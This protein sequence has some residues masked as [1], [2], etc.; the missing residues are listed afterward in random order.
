[1]LTETNVQSVRLWDPQ[2]RA[3]WVPS[4]KLGGTNVQGP[5]AMGF[6]IEGKYRVHATTKL[7]GAVGKVRTTHTH[8]SEEAQAANVEIRVRQ[9]GGDKQVRDFFLGSRMGG[10]RENRP[11][12]VH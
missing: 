12:R 11:Y 1:M 10:K 9:P 6:K 3:N 4:A 2:V 8:A 7:V 5:R